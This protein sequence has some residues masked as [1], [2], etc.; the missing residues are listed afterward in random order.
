MNWTASRSPELSPRISQ[1]TPISA[2]KASPGRSSE[3][4]EQ[5]GSTSDKS[6]ASRAKQTSPIGTINLL[7]A[8]LEHPVLA[9]S[10]QAP[11][12][13]AQ[14]SR[15]VTRVLKI[16]RGC[17]GRLS[18][19]LQS[20]PP[21]MLP[22]A[23]SL[24]TLRHVASGDRLG[25]DGLVPLVRPHRQRPPA[26]IVSGLSRPAGLSARVHANPVLPS[27][28]CSKRIAA[29]CSRTIGG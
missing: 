14:V 10:R 24:S 8:N 27:P 22:S 4:T 19:S 26:S 17:V 21:R 20:R 5:Q 7:F 28:G 18:R 3:Q 25:D 16:A 6:S 11:A 2:G 15:G 13:E 12:T 29:R 23:G 1:G 9:A